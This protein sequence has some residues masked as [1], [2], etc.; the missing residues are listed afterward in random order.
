M[1]LADHIRLPQL[2]SDTS[3]HH[4]GIQLSCGTASFGWVLTRVTFPSENVVRV[5]THLV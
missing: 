3:S 2:S 5:I 4:T 1:A